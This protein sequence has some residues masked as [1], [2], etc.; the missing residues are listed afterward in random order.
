M[1]DRGSWSG[2]LDSAAH[3][4]GDILVDACEVRAKIDPAK[5]MSF[6][7]SIRGLPLTYD[8]AT[9]RLSTP[10]VRCTLPTENGKVGLVILVD[11]TS[12]E[13]FAQGGRVLLSECFLP[14]ADEHRISMSGAGAKIESL[15]CWTLK[16]SWHSSAK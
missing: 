16:S 2:D 9:R 4:L 15:D 5:A 1:I 12:V 14:A 10:R 8:V 6:T 13:V 11:R 3:P 7:F